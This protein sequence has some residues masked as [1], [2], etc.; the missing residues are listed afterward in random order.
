[1]IKAYGTTLVLLSLDAGTAHERCLGVKN[2]DT[3]N[4]AFS[5][6]LEKLS[7]VTYEMIVF[8]YCTSSAPLSTDHHNVM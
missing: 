4:Y 1:M 3:S 2:V 5:G 7:Q 8:C 6:S